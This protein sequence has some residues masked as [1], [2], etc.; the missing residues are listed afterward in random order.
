MG[1]FAIGSASQGGRFDVDNVVLR[2]ARGRELLANGDF[3]RGLAHW[4][5][6]SDRSHLPWHV[7]NLFLHVLFEQGG[8][9]VALL[10]MLLAGSLWRITAGHARGH[11]IA[12]PVAAA[13]IGFAVVG[14]FD[15]LLDVPRI[16]FLFYLL[17]LLG[18]GVRTPPPRAAR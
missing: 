3:S 12:P 2:D 18:L 7:K 4:F 1:V 14:L 13:L 5:F 15:S 16:A 8:V 9:A 10:S 17:L 6:T 11:P